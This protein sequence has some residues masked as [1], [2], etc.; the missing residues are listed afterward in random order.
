MN[1]VLRKRHIRIWLLL[2]PILVAG[3]V[4]AIVLRPSAL[5]SQNES[6][7]GGDQP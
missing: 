2:G 4:S 7:S 5:P 6:F 1:R 3:V